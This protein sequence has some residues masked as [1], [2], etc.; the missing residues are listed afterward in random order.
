LPPPKWTEFW[1]YP[2]VVGLAVLAIVVTLAW[3]GKANIAELFATA[4]IRRGQLWRL[5]TPIFPH[6]DIL[7]LAFN[8][9]WLWIFGTVVEKILGHAKMILLVLLFAVGS[10]AWDFGLA[11]GGVG[12]SGVGYG[13]FGLLSVLSDR[14][15][16]FRGVLDK[17]T[18]NLFIGWFFICI[19]ATVTNIFPVAN[20]AHGAGAVLGVVTAYA[21]VLPS[22]RPLLASVCGV[23]VLSGVLAAT[24]GRPLVNLSG[25]GGYDEAKWG[26]DA[27]LK[28]DNQGAI[29]WLRESTRYR[30]KEPIFWYDL[31]VAYDRAE[32][33]V[34]AK[35]AFRRAVALDPGNQ[36][37][38]KAFEGMQ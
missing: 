6:L 12:L 15:D 11:H 21:I 16:R 5:V 14:D 35:D 26:Y 31:G 27:L 34:A 25:K 23:F 4:E 37:Y 36:E 3:W 29:R 19:L 9:Y 13:L 32:Q 28:G 24:I 33:S 8:L 7:H 22:R 2:V 30:T 38:K 1:R 17:R 18:S 10:N 20:V